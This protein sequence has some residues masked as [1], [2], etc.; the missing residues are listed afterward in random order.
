MESE[1]AQHERY[2]EIMHQA[3]LGTATIMQNSPDCSIILITL[4]KQ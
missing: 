4:S 1:I 3:Y 2:E